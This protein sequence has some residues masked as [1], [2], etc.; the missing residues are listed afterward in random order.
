[1]GIAQFQVNTHFF[2]QGSMPARLFAAV[3]QALPP[4]AKIVGMGEHPMCSVFY[5]NIESA[6]FVDTPSGY[7]LPYIIAHFKRQADGTA[8]LDK[9]DLDEAYGR[10]QLHQNAMNAAIAAVQ[11][12]KQPPPFV[13]QDVCDHD[14]KTYDSGFVTRYR[15]CTKC[16]YKENE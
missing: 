6:L 7:Q 5:F 9:V 11:N 2:Q 10:K 12:Y 16:P 14:M 3:F 8:Y 1:M 4:D 15:Y 13:M